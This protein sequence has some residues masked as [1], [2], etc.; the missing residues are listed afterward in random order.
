[1]GNVFFVAGVILLL[2]AG[3]RFVVLTAS[4]LPY[5][6]SSF[7]F[8]RRIFRGNK[9]PNQGHPRRDL[10]LYSA[11]ELS[12]GLIRVT[13]S[14]A[15]ASWWLWYVPLDP[16]ARDYAWLLPESMRAI[17]LSLLALGVIVL[18]NVLI[19]SYVW[20]GI[21]KRQAFVYLQSVATRWSFREVR[22]IVLR[23]IKSRKKQKKR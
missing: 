2:I 13:L 12:T 14:V 8:F 20:Q 1:L 15:I 17:T 7:Q 18:A 19:S 23:Q 11:T 22:S 4:P 6:T 21:S 3:S 10:S 9:D 5:D 16:L